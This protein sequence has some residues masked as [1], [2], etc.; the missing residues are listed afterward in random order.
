MTRAEGGFSLLEML[1]VLAILALA[2][3]IVVPRLG[4]GLPG[5]RAELA[6]RLV[7]NAVDELRSLAIRENRA[8]TLRI[9]SGGR[10]L[11]PGRGLA[12]AL[13]AGTTATLDRESLRFLPDGRTSGG[14]I[15]VRGGG[16]EI[17]LDVDWLT[18][19]V[20][21]RTETAP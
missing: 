7:A 11:S 4:A 13:P 15:R 21:Q 18:G 3:T 17:L 20:R 5:A 6:A 14:T 16:R 10:E 2:A 12:I 19:L 9:A 8:E 1:L